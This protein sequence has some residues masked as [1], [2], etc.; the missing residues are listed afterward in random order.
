MFILRILLKAALLP[1]VLILLLVKVIVKV[2][3]QI[4]SII[5]GGLILFV[6]GCLIYTITK[7]A[8]S[9]TFLLALIEAG[10]MGITIGTAVIESL[11]DA[12][13]MGIASI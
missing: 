9:Q 12:A 10:I 7:Q 1:V 4:S 6:A 5:L 11:I 3:M 8:W 2:G 13:L